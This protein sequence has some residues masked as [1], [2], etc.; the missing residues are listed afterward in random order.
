SSQSLRGERDAGGLAPAE[1]DRVGLDAV[2]EDDQPVGLDAERQRLAGGQLAFGAGGAGDG[3]G[4]AS[5][6]NQARRGSAEPGRVSVLRRS[7]QAER[8]QP[9]APVPVDTISPEDAWASGPRSGA[10]IV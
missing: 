10:M 6:T 2:A 1:F 5:R 9:V 8:H 4:Q 3:E 7:S